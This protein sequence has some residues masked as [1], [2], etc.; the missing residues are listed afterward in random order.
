MFGQTWS[1]PQTNRPWVY[2]NLQVFWGFLSCFLGILSLRRGIFEKP[3]GP[4][5][6]ARRVASWST[7]GQTW[8]NCQTNPPWKY[9]NPPVRYPT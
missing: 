1:N 7:F 9:S 2:R 3:S 8:S 6:R 4:L 5:D